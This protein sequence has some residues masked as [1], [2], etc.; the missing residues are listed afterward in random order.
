[1]TI[2]DNAIIKTQ[3]VLPGSTTNVN[4]SSPTTVT[5]RTTNKTASLPTT[6]SFIRSDL[7]EKVHDQ[8]TF[9]RQL[10]SLGVTLEKT[11]QES[12]RR[13]LTL[14]LPL[15][16]RMSSTDHAVC[17]QPADVAWIWHC[18]RLKTKFYEDYI[19]KTFGADAMVNTQIN[20]SLAAFQFLSEKSASQETFHTMHLW[21]LHCPGEAFFCAKKTDCATGK[22]H[23]DNTLQC[24]VVGFDIVAMTKRQATFLWR[25][26]GSEFHVSNS[27]ALDPILLRESVVNYPKFLQLV[28]T[29]DFDWLLV[30]TYAIDLVWRT[31]ILASV[32]RYKEDCVAFLGRPFH[33]NKHDGEVSPNDLERPFSKTCQLWL[34]AYGTDLNGRGGLDRESPPNEFFSATWEGIGAKPT[35]QV[36][37]SSAAVAIDIQEDNQRVP[38]TRLTATKAKS[39]LLLVGVFALPA[40]IVFGFDTISKIVVAAL[41]FLMLNFLHNLEHHEREYPDEAYAGFNWWSVQPK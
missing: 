4:T 21:E 14:W 17:L 27:M 5:T 36:E 23:C 26:S 38:T 24:T 7:E 2:P 22:T 20:G 8:V 33:R 10:H 11:S 41:Y 35:K 15:L 19:H 29:T 18:H 25:I 31:H 34:I 28:H 30:S 1:M 13:Y 16:A 3:I 40:Y 9:L 12:M 39:F 6:R 32:Q 37:T